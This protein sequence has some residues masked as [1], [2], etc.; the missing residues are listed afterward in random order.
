MA[1]L[2]IRLNGINYEHFVLTA[3]TKSDYLAL[4]VIFDEIGL[5]GQ[6]ERDERSKEAMNVIYI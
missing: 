1:N 5:Y 3:L 4:L 2:C 6:K